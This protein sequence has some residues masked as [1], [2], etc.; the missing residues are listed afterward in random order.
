M[1]RHL[2]RAE[3]FEA[4]LLR[5]FLAADS[6][7]VSG[8]ALAKLVGVSR[9]AVWAHLHRLGEEGFEFEAVHSRGYRLKR[10]PAGLA[11][12]LVRALLA[13]PGPNP[14]ILF[15]PSVDST[16][17]EAERQLTAGRSTPF[18][19]L[20]AAQTQGRGRFGRVWH[21][22]AGG[23]LY[24]SF[25]F[26]PD[27]PPDRMHLFTLWMGLNLCE[28]LAAFVGVAPGLKWPNDLYFDERKVGGMLTEARIDADQTRDLVF[29]LGLNV[30]GT[31]AAWPRDLARSATSL[32][33]VKG[34]AIDLNRLTAAVIGRILLA[35]DAFAG[36][37][38]LD[39]LADL[40]H[41][42]DLLAGRKIT[43]VQGAL[44]HTG[45]ARG[46]DDEGA[47]LLRTDAGRTLRFRA[48][49]VTLQKGG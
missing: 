5:E 7:F 14:T 21:S 44:Q 34:E 47:L 15:F 36:A 43:V 9:V 33:Q 30:N 32:A 16:N 13:P 3:E 25:G 6:D 1:Q 11:A 38:V 27:L 17:E 46:I 49:E 2:H 4:T 20:A 48:G 22:P 28:L 10:R 42:F 29:G 18:V 40:W 45:T 19:V 37:K 12:P 35:Y 8:A 31:A 39:A 24:L 41:R 23:H 26:R